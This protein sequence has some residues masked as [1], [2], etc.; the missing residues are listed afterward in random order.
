M[1]AALSIPTP[2][3]LYVHD[4]LTPFVRER[5]GENSTEYDLSK[6]FL[7]Y[8]QSQ[9]HVKIGTIDEELSGLIAQTCPLKFDVTFG[10]GYKGEEIAELLH[11]RWGSFPNI[12]R[13][14]IT[15]IE[16]EGSK[17]YVLVSKTDKSIE[18]QIAETGDIRSCALIDDVLYTGFTMKSIIE[19]LPM[20]KIESCHLFFT[21]GL[22]ETK[23]EFEDMGC[24]VHIGMP[25]AGKIEVD[26]STIST[27]NL[28]TEG[29]IRTNDGDLTYCDRPQWMEAWFPND[30]DI[31]MHLCQS[32]M[33]LL[34]SVSIEERKV[35]PHVFAT[36]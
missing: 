21:R 14:D 10:F 34:K 29:A 16:K 9:P 5:Y 22:T 7:K 32:I 27:M 18:D 8:V 25:L 6:R 11:G 33:H 2:K 17:E 13:L 23:K 19:K 28:I 1:N 24:T 20:D 36:K 30:T 3:L 4:N 15:R 26:A 31:I 12:I 35:K